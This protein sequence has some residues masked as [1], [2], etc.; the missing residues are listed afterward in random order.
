MSEDNVLQRG[1]TDSGGEIGG[2]FVGQMTVRGKNPLLNGERA[3]GVGMEHLFI[4]VCLDKKTV[5]SGDMMDNRVVHVTE[6]R[7]HAESN[8]R[9]T[10]CEADRVGGIMR[11][12]KSG[13]LNRTKGKAAP[14]GENFP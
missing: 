11:D 3:L 7:Q 10:Q 14:G 2:S 9:T 1:R 5:D 12:G 6:V 4:V 8:A 13:N